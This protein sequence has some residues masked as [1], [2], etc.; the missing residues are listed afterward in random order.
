[1][2]THLK[3]K[4]PCWYIILLINMK[5]TFLYRLANFGLEYI[6]SDSR[7]VR[8]ACFLVTF[9]GNI[10]ILLLL[11]SHVCILVYYYSKVKCVFDGVFIYCYCKAV[12]I[13]DGIF[14]YYYSKVTC[15]FDGVF[16]YCCSKITYVFSGI[17]VLFSVVLT[18]KPDKCRKFRVD[19][20]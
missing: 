13:F 3:L 1:M 17:L 18:K 10:F 4:M 14:V 11:W 6:L 8:P 9:A 5:W 12:C 20:I 7:T 16:I 15:I 2:C 19:V